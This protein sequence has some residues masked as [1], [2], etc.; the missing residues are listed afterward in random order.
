[1]SGLDW[2]DHVCQRMPE[3]HQPEIA[4]G[5]TGPLFKMGEGI[6]E[7]T[8]EWRKSVGNAH[9]LKEAREEKDSETD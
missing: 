4:K 5:V 7:E 2:M 3:F 1:M 9:A 6:Q 8:A